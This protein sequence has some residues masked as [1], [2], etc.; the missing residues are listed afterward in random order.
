MPRKYLDENGHLLLGSG[1][2]GQDA[3]GVWCIRPPGCH[4]GPLI[5][6][7]KITEHED[8]TITVSPSIECDWRDGPNWHGFLERGEWRKL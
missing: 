8:G 4:M 2:Y 3:D 7:H 6:G 1:D 5:S